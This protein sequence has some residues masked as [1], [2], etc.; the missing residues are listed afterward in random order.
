MT[1]FFTINKL[2]LGTQSVTL[3]STLRHPTQLRRRQCAARQQKSSPWVQ[4]ISHLFLGSWTTPYVMF[5]SK[6]LKPAKK[7]SQSAKKF[8]SRQKKDS[9]GLEDFAPLFGKLTTPYVMF[10][11]EKLKF[12]LL[13]RRKVQI[14]PKKVPLARQKKFPSGLEHFVRDFCC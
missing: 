6:K 8:P 11:R 13:I 5:E 7:V 10:E 4:R 9:Q 1:G 3:L 12:L 14:E 2:R